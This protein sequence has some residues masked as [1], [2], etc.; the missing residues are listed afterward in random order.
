MIYRVAAGRYFRPEGGDM[1]DRPR[2][3]L[4][5]GPQRVFAHVLASSLAVSVANFTVWFAVTF[6]VYL[7]TRSVFAT[8]VIAGVFLVATAGTGT[9]FG[10]LVDRYRKHAVIQASAIAS[11][12]FYAMALALYLLLPEAVW[13]DPASPLL[14]VFVVVLMLGVIAGNIRGIALPTLVTLLVPEH[15]RDRA[16]GLVGTTTGVSF[17]VTSVISGLLVAFDGMRSTILLAMVV[18]AASFLHLAGVRIEERRVVTT[19]DGADGGPRGG[20]KGT[21]QGGGGGPRVLPPVP[22]A[23][24]K[25]FIR[26]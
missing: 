9:W 21:P 17:L 13:R 11:L 16:N 14:W 5:T 15:L 25:K 26:R 19:G 22:F 12:V 6:W 4:R 10:S 1:S 23:R 2:L 24:F 20:F 18:S 3:E 7:E 8:G